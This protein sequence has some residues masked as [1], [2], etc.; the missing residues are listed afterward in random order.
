MKPDQILWYKD[1]KLVIYFN[2]MPNVAV[3]YVTPT[4]TKDEIKSI[5]K[6]PFINKE[7]LNV[8]IFDR[9]K[10]KSYKFTIP[11]G[12]CFDGASIPRIFWRLIG[13]N[14]DNNFLIPALIHDA[15]CENH[16]HLDYDRAL[17]TNIFNAL[18]YASGVGN[19]KRFLMKNSVAC[20]Q[21]LFCK[22]RNK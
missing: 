4:S 2:E 17:S 10:M 8:A 20:Y 12:Y 5:K 3:R 14:T 11:K 22:W 13:P 9:E 7:K 15:L 19:F 1:D 18:L 21:T 6:Y 16:S